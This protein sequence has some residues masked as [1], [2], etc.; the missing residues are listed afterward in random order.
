[1]GYEIEVGEVLDERFKI[2]ALV[3]EG[4]MANVFLAVDL[5]TQR[6]V[7][8]KVPLM[9][10]ESHPAFS[11]QFQREEAIAASLDH[12]AVIRVI[13]VDKNNRS[14]PYIVTEFLEGRTLNTLIQD[15]RP[16]DLDLAVSIVSQLCAAFAYIHEKGVVHRDLKPGN[17]MCCHDGSL[18][19]LDFGL[20]ITPKQKRVVS[21]GL[22]GS[23][24][25]AVYMAPEQVR[26]RL[27]DARVDVY[28]IGSILYELTTGNR[29]FPMEDYAEAAQAR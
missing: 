26:G 13:A 18:R 10:Y 29:P 7:A 1:M 14:R 8:V 21:T 11:R 23:I 15:Q 2:T 27:G 28:A 12:P 3:S 20:A 4:G 9:K 5:E 19:I 16:I 6:H 25:T 24:G 22:D 17:I